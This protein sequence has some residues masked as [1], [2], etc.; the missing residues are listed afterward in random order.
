MQNL[1]L[2]KQSSLD[3]EQHLSVSSGV[4]ARL[5][6]V[7]GHCPLVER[8]FRPFET[9]VTSIISQQLSAK[10]AETIKMRI[11][12]LVPDLVPQ[13]FCQCH[14]ADC[15]SQGFHPQRFVILANWRSKS[16]PANSIL[17]NCGA[18]LKMK[19]KRF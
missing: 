19:L 18:R 14:Q 6:A 7:H 13:V 5:F 1:S 4:M 15:V 9:L 17:K 8:E 2:T 12:T 3:A 11:R 10:A 16:A